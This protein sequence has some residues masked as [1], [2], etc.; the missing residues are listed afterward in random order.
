MIITTDE[1]RVIFPDLDSWTD[2]K[3]CRKLKAIEQTVRSYTNNNFQFSSPIGDL[4]VFIFQ[5]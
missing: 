2:E 3:L 4:Y 5:E 1:A